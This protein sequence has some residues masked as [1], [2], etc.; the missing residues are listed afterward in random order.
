[1]KRLQFQQKDKKWADPK[2]YETI[3]TPTQ[4]ARRKRVARMR[5][6]QMAEFLKPT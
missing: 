4:K 1:M 5:R 6:L 2:A 3:L